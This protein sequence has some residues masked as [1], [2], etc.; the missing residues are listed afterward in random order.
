MATTT[1]GVSSIISGV[2]I[3]GGS[4]VKVAV[5]VGNSGGDV[6]VGGRATM[7]VGV[8]VSGGGGTMVGVTTL[9]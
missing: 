7:G 9:K 4:G 2:G 3:S 1:V 5:G 8:G 6:G